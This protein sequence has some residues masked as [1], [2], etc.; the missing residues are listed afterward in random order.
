[1]GKVNNL[2]LNGS[3]SGEVRNLFIGRNRKVKWGRVGGALTVCALVASYVTD[4]V[5]YASDLHN[6]E[7]STEYSS[8]VD[9]VEGNFSVDL[10]EYMEDCVNKYGVILEQINSYDEMT[11]SE[12]YNFRLQLVDD[13][14]FVEHT[15]L[16]FVKDIGYEKYEFDCVRSDLTVKYFDYALAPVERVIL[17]DGNSNKDLKGD[18]KDT[19]MA[20]CDLQNWKDENGHYVTDWKNEKEFSQFVSDVQNTIYTTAYML[21]N[22]V[23]KDNKIIEDNNTD[24]LEPI[25]PVPVT[26]S[27]KSR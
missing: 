1:M 22:Y 19:A 21:K 2:I 16:S 13:A 4:V 23:E 11:L 12:Q 25:E 6:L 24:Y 7:I 26:I 18:L 3:K 9:Q 20:V 8:Y 5:V 10:P 15:S 17:S 27:V 14:S